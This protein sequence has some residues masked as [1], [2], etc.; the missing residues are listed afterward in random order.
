MLADALVTKKVCIIYMN[1]DVC[2]KSCCNNEILG[3]AY[4]LFGLVAT[5][6]GGY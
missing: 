5:S 3:F 2:W 1:R 4:F 6:N